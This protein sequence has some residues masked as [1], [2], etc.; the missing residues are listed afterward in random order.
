MLKTTR[1]FC[2]KERDAINHI[3]WCCPNIKPFW[4]Q[5]QTAVNERC[6]NV[7]SIKFNENIVLSGHDANFRSDDVLDLIILLAIVLFFVFTNVKFERL[8]HN[9]IYLNS[10]LGLHLN[11]KNKHHSIMNMSYHKFITNW[12]SYKT[13]VEV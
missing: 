5:L 13:L 10:I 7:S 4:E 6:V 3:F 12:H 2:R 9:F 8:H 11:Y 1:S